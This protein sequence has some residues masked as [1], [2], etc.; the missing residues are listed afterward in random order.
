MQ[1]TAAALALS[2]VAASAARAQV[3]GGMM[4]P[5]LVPMP[6]NMPPQGPR[7]E[8]PEPVPKAPLTRGAVLDEVSG[9]VKDLDRKSHK[10]T[11]ESVSGPVTLALDRNTMVYTAN[12][13]GTVLDIAPG[14]QIRAGRNADYLAYWVQLRVP[15]KPEPAATPAQGTGPAGGAAAPATESAG[16][17]AGPAPAPPT[18]GPGAVPPGSNPPGSSGG[19]PPSTGGTPAGGGAPPSGG[20]TSPR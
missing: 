8:R 20:G 13:L 11:V 1:K 4:P 14:Q 10:L 19:V 17:G 3:P 6:G 5:S 15:P 18:S 9:L 16:K 2:L 12:G 7:S